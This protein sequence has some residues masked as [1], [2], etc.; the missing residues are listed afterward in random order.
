MAAELSRPKLL[1][2]IVDCFN[3]ALQ[4]QFAQEYRDCRQWTFEVVLEFIN[5]QICNL[6]FRE[7]H[8]YNISAIIDE[9][10]TS[11]AHRKSYFE[12]KQR[13]GPITCRW[14]LKKPI[15]AYPKMTR[16]T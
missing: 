12:R 14:L 15:A 9:D 16:I 10:E 8:S 3:P 5:R 7:S 11:K 1:F 2:R 13:P 6:Q 4:A